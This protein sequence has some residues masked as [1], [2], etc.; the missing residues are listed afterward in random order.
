MKGQQLEYFRLVMAFY[1]KAGN[2]YFHIFS[3]VSLP[4]SSSSYL[5]IFVM[6]ERERRRIFDKDIAISAVDS[7][8]PKSW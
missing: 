3:K 8:E 6:R 7:E 5:P 2:S 4:P 1:A